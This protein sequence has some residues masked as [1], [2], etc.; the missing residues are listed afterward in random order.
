M[1]ITI[2]GNLRNFTE[3]PRGAETNTARP[4]RG[5]KST[6]ESAS[7]WKM[8]LT[9]D[10]GPCSSLSEIKEKTKYDQW[11]NCF[12]IS[13]QLLLN[14]P[15]VQVV[16][17]H[18]VLCKARVKARPSVLWCYKKEL[19]FSSHR[20]V[21]QFEQLVGV[22]CFF[23]YGRFPSVRGIYADKVAIS[24]LK[25]T[26]FIKAGSNGSFRCCFVFALQ[27]H[28]KYALLK[29]LGR[30]VQNLNVD[31]TSGCNC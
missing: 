8:V 7:Q 9:C 11:K 23:E 30:Q 29:C 26:V 13:V 2:H 16:I 6:T 19:G 14:V 4:C 25:E 21:F 20:F 15:I 5:R 22:V 17:L 24:D 27:N 31:S 3:H 1:L 28:Q 18:H 10:R 12:D